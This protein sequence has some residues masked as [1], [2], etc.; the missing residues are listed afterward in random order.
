VGPLADSLLKL[1]DAELE[2]L[3]TLVGDVRSCYTAGDASS[4]GFVGSES[5]RTAGARAVLVLP[6]WV[7]RQRFGTLVVAHSRPMRLTGDQ[8]EPLELLADHAAAVL[9]SML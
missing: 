5:L 8:V 9:G 2:A 7:Q 1:T 4:R 6:L 3:S